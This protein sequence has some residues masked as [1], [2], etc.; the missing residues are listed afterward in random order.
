MRI[1]KEEYCEALN[2][3]ITYKRKMDKIREYLMIA[4]ES[5]L[6]EFVWQYIETLMEVT[7][8]VTNGVDYTSYFIN[9]LDCGKKWKPGTVIVDGFD[10]RLDT[11]ERV[12]DFILATQQKAEMPHSKWGVSQTLS[13]RKEIL[14]TVLVCSRCG[15]TVD[16]KSTNH[17]DECP[18]C[19]TVMY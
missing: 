10:V 14:E 8:E 6:N 5:P 15:H 1:T 7:D 2:N 12:Y 17:Y 13:P 19:N 16:V 11:P 18:E 9:E 3:I 4:T